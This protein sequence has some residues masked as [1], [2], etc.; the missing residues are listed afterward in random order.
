ML[1]CLSSG[2]R[3]RY[4]QDILRALALPIES[5]L[6]F[7]YDKRWVT[8][9]VLQ[10]IQDHTI[11]GQEILIAYADQSRPSDGSITT[12]AI[13][14]V[15]IRLATVVF[16]A[17][18][19]RTVSLIFS[20]GKVTYASDLDAF[21][22][23]VANLTGRNLP[24]WV[25]G[26]PHGFYCTELNSRPSNFVEIQDLGHWED[27][28]NQISAHR[29]F[30]CEETFFTV[31][32]L[33]TEDELKAMGAELHH[34]PWIRELP[35]NVC[36]ELVIY[37]YHPTKSPAN[38]EISISA[39]PELKLQSLDKSRL[40]S[41][42]DLK[43]FQVQSEDPLFRIQGSWISLIARDPMVDQRFELEMSICVRGARWKRLGIAAVIALGLTGAQIIPLVTRGDLTPAIKVV[44]A[45]TILVLSFVVGLAAVWGIRRAI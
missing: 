35:A 43:K 2:D 18:P 21:N 27:V 26:N 29:D 32:G 34:L 38:L 11:V 16:A 37:H 7:R 40:D 23:E 28:V 6:Q 12:G 42:Y 36:R 14:L 30:E 20:L 4:R 25:N 22:N 15:P 8:D 44:S 1:I 13:K 3:P 39:G 33:L 17:A 45:L 24:R 5:D 41:R 19:G 9:G 31:I 10:M